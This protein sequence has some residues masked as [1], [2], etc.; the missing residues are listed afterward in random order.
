MLK[1]SGLQAVTAHPRAGLPQK[2]EGLL[3]ECVMEALPSPCPFR[4]QAR[5]WAAAPRGTVRRWLWVL[6][7][8]SPRASRTAGMQRGRGTGH[9]GVWAPWE[10]SWAGA[11]RGAQEGSRP[12][13]AGVGVQPGAGAELQG[14]SQVGPVQSPPRCPPSGLPASLPFS[15]LRGWAG[16]GERPE[17]LGSWGPIRG[18]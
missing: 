5:T 6:G 12:L 7:L 17:Q 11:A 18:C 13:G 3:S 4:A 8:L 14:K 1:L 16:R 15:S 2:Q 10:V 9:P